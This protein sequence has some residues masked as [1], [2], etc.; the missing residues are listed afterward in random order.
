MPDETNNEMKACHSIN[1]TNDQILLKKKIPSGFRYKRKVINLS[2]FFINIT[3]R[4]FFVE[5][6]TNFKEN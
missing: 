2:A 5:E 1:L 4:A 3:K 6:K